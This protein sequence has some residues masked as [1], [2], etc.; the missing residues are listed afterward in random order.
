MQDVYGLI[1]D[2]YNFLETHSFRTTDWKELNPTEPYYFFVEKNFSM[3][4]EYD[5][6]I[7][8]IIKIFFD[9]FT[10]GVKTHRDDF[11][12]GFT[13]EEVEQKMLTFTSDLPDE[14][15]REGLNLKDTTELEGWLKGEKVKK[16]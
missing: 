16:D 6:F 7:S 12:I 1:E 13:K 14:I 8:D 5:K 15:V 4:E 9:R 3:Q 10:S 11:V 2:K